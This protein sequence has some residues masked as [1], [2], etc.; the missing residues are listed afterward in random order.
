MR[1]DFFEFSALRR[2]KT[3]YFQPFIIQFKQYKLL[4]N[5]RSI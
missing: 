1:G 3:Q 4:N 5:V 2:A